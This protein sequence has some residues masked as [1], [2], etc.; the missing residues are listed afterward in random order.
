MWL[1]YIPLWYFHNIYLPWDHDDFVDGAFSYGDHQITHCIH[2]SVT[3]QG[4]SKS[5]PNLLCG[6]P[7]DF[8]NASIQNNVRMIITQLIIG[9][10]HIVELNNIC[11]T[12]LHLLVH[13]SCRHCQRPNQQLK[14]HTNRAAAGISN[15]QS[16][17]LRTTV[18]I[19]MHVCTELHS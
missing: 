3:R 12:F 18:Y 13:C 1:D 11:K 10:L 16:E 7:T 15:N 19:P 14:S 4:V 5:I 9:A 8:G 2:T 6:S 17:I